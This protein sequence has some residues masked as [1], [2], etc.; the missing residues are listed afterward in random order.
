M[1]VRLV[2]ETEVEPNLELDKQGQQE[3]AMEM[4]TDVLHGIL[5]DPTKSVP[6]IFKNIQVL[7]PFT[8]KEGVVYGRP[9]KNAGV[10]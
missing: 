1:R 9:K 7:R 2:F 8:R 10:Q 4:A 6:E 5:E 3:E